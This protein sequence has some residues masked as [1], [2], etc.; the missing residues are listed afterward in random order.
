MDLSKSLPRAASGIF[1]AAVLVTGILA[2]ADRDDAPRFSARTLDGERFTNQTL[3]GHPV[4]IQFWATW[5]P[6]CRS[7]QPAVDAIARDYADKGLVVLAV[8]LGE[9]KRVVKSYLDRSPRECKIV[10][11]EDTN[12]AAVFG[13]R[14]VPLYVLIGADGK[15]AGTQ[16]GAG[17]EALLRRFLRRAGLE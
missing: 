7:D 12:L 9:S 13:A 15:V 10:L 6:R 5:C 11:M 2:A 8:D 14:L 4:L 17:G 16:P 1:L 3:A